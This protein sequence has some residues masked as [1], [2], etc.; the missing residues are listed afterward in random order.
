PY[1]V[2]APVLGGIYLAPLIEPLGNLAPDFV[3]WFFG[4]SQKFKSTI[5]ALGQGHFGPFTRT[6]MPAEFRDTWAALELKLCAMKDAPMTIDDYKTATTA[7]E[8]Q[9]MDRNAARLA[10]T[11]GNRRGRARATAHMKVR[12]SYPPRGLALATGGRLPAGSS[13]LA[14]LLAVPARAGD[15]TIDRAN[16]AQQPSA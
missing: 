16:M 10:R 5:A 13:T 14:R 2:M 3:P 8:Q 1:R 6:T 15:V 11:V 4:D 9:D 12:E 7:V